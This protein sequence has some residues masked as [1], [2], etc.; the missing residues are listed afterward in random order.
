MKKRK[1]LG[2]GV[3]I[4][5]LF[6]T[7]SISLFMADGAWAKSATRLAV[8][9]NGIGG[10]YYIYSGALSQ[11]IN[12]YIP[13]VEATVEVCAGSSVGKWGQILNCE[14]RLR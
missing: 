1:C 12:K 10:V 11:M 5:A 3:W 2:L 8:G 7:I 6:L 13:G 4:A 9:G 14:Y